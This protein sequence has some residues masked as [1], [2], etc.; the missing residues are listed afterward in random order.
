MRAGKQRVIH[1]LFLIPQAFFLWIVIVWIPD[2]IS[3]MG[4]I[5]SF[6]IGDKPLPEL[7]AW[8]LSFESAFMKMEAYSIEIAFL[9]S[10]LFLFAGIWIL[11]GKQEDRTVLFRSYVFQGVSAMAGFFA[12]FTITLAITL[13]LIAMQ[14]MSSRP[15]PSPVWACLPWVIGLVLA[16]ALIPRLRNFRNHTQRNSQD[17]ES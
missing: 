17:R 8:V 6:L 14:L 9:L 11:L 13:P 15:P 5:F 4:E 3:G 7:T 1:G 16:V 2:I 12:T 10:S